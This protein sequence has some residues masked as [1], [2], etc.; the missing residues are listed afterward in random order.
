MPSTA[1]GSSKQVASGGDLFH[2]ME[3]LGWNGVRPEVCGP[4]AA[5]F[6]SVQKPVDVDG[7]IPWG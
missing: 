2:G 3:W 4:G 1:K 5:I 6:V 7:V